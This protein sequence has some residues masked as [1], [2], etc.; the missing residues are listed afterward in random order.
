MGLTM[1]QMRFLCHAI[2][3]VL[4]DEKLDSSKHRLFVTAANRRP[5]LHAVG[6]GFTVGLFLLCLLLLY[7]GIF[8]FL[9]MQRKF[10]Q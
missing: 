3:S 1:V 10:L 7:V 8:F 9:K 2:T 4:G 6:C 5:S